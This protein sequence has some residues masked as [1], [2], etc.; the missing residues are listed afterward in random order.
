MKHSVAWTCPSWGQTRTSYRC[1]WASCTDL[2]QQVYIEINLK[3]PIIS[4]VTLEI[5]DHEIEKTE[6]GGV[7]WDYF[8]FPG[9]EGKPSVGHFCKSFTLCCARHAKPC[10][11]GDWKPRRWDGDAL[12]TL[13]V[14]PWFDLFC[15]WPLVTLL[16]DSGNT[17]VQCSESFREGV[18]TCS[19]HLMHSQ[20]HLP[21]FHPQ[22][23]IFCKM[24]I[25]LCFLFV[26]RKGKIK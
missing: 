26:G 4:S 6:T 5:D 11:K 16:G 20:M 14:H 19:K 15:W 1:S 9:C 10:E 24:K 25:I 22:N 13:L 7:Q 3:A 21:F 17:S 12:L 8:F 2:P 18:N 23:S